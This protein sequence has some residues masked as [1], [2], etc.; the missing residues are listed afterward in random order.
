MLT[1]LRVLRMARADEELSNKEQNVVNN[2]KES[3][4]QMEEEQGSDSRD[5]AVGR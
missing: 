5:V 3:D 4:N 1:W 2:R